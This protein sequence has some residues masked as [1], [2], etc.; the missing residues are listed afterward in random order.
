MLI[1][2]IIIGTIFFYNKIE[3]F[4]NDMDSLKQNHQKEIELILQKEISNAVDYINYKK[5]RAI[6]R[7]KYEIKGYVNQGY[8]IA[9]GIYE[10]YK[11]TKSKD[12]I[13][14]IIKVA[15]RDA[16]FFD[17][18]GYF[19]IYTTKGKSILHP[20]FPESEN[21]YQHK[22][23]ID[24][25][26]V[27][28]VK[29]MSNIVKKNNEGF[30]EYYFYNINTQN[31]KLGYV[32]SLGFYDLYI[33]SAEYIKDFEK[34]VK[35]EIFERLSTVR[36]G[37]DG[38]LFIDGF[39]GT[40]LMHPMKPEIVGKNLIEYK[41][42]NG[43][44]VIKDLI[45]AAKTE[46]GKFVYYNWHRPKNTSK[47]I[48]KV[49]FAMGIPE[50]TWMI[51]GGLYLDDLNDDLKLKEEK[52]KKDLI[53]DISY[54]LIFLILISIL[55]FMLLQWF[56]KQTKKT[57]ENIIDFFVEASEKN[58]YLDK[59]DISFKDF[60]KLA[61][62]INKMIKTRIENEN[63]LLEFQEE[64]KQQA[65]TDYLTKIY[66]RKYFMETSKQILSLAK[67]ENKNLSLLMIDI[68]KF[69][70]INDNY[71]H[72]IGDEVI[73]FVANTLK[74]LTRNSDIVARVGG[75]E[76]AILLPNI[77]ENSAFIIAEKLRKEISSNTIS[78]ENIKIT[79]SIGVSC[80]KNENDSVISIIKKAD[81]ALYYSKE[82]GR[83]K[84]SLY[85]DL[86]E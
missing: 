82:N 61:D 74:S 84:V 15:L 86:K 85:S 19:F 8:N 73:I 65:I 42:V 56:N 3:K 11:H 80:Y 58:I 76:F 25:K 75:E 69:K 28:V 41:D 50:W 43:I 72:N 68:D 6:K 9:N 48:N 2:S 47:E 67:R 20:I 10:K 55:I 40:I 46:N 45:S 32:K 57:F 34:T 49:S 36:F 38:Y 64:L 35:K 51:G 30:V 21:S 70:L 54:S 77:D 78:K 59:K 31:K 14:E 7:L 83:N 79:I 1:I 37:K 5:N 62:A 66:N 24:K 53:K 27:S 12:E 63:K 81:K 29:N 4:Q 26:G 16:R 39:D 33:G 71:G 18:R 13:I 60:K 52:F 23:F 44:Y 22:N 17:D